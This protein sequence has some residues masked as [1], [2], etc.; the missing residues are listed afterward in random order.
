VSL[1]EQDEERAAARAAALRRQLEE[2]N[3]RYHALDAPTISDAEYDRLLR[4]LIEIEE[5]YPELRDPSSPTQRVGAAPS[6]AF[7]AHVHRVP[8]L[9]L[10][11]SFSLEELREF[12]ARVK[13]MLRLG[14]DAAV[15]YVC[16]LKIDGL[17]VSMTY[18]EGRLVVGATRGDGTQG[19]DVTPNLRTIRSIP[20]SLRDGAPS[21]R[22]EVRGEVYLTH[23]EFQAVN[24]ERE[25]EGLPLFANPRNAAA[26]SLRQLDSSITAR[27]RLQA[28]FYGL[29]ESP[30]TPPSQWELIRTLGEWGFRTNPHRRLCASI[31]EVIPF[32]D[33]W[34]T[35]RAALP[36]EI[37]GVVVKVNERALQEE[38]G[39]VSRSPRWATAYKYP[40]AEATTRIQAIQVQVGRTGALTP[41]AIMDPVVVAGVTVTRAT[42]HNEDEI[43]RKDIRVGDT[44]VIRRAGEVIPEVVA[45]LTEK[46]T[47][48]ETPF[49]MPT[50]CP[51]CGADVERGD[52]EAVARCVGIACPAQVQERLR[53][54][55]SRGA[56]DIDGLGP[57]H[58]EQLV[59]LGF[60]HDPADLYALTKEQ[61]LTLERL[62]ERSAQNLLDA[63]DRSRSRPLARL[64]FGLGIRHVGE[65]VARLLAEHFGSIER[66]RAASEEQLAAV[67]GVGP[68]IAASVARFFRQEETTAALEKLK[69]AGVLPEAAGE[70]EQGERPFAG[71]TFVFTGGLETM[72]R[73]EA[74]EAVRA[75][76]GVA[77]GS[78]SKKTRYVVAGEGGG[79]K[80]ARAQELGVPVI[81]EAEFREM[82]EG[83]G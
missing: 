64:L 69:A 67:P 5:Q 43:R 60:V 82:L 49:V 47:G 7:R 42:L 54:F 4:E 8:M 44:V 29:G 6:S 1:F 30:V 31:D 39:A 20:L 34:Q 19:E 22:V 57:A 74:E 35:E 45:V 56:M 72:T 65:H 36:Y 14:A 62:A 26:G 3:Y 9:S 52:G 80:L 50:K 79:S 24:Q 41:V 70:H 18:A 12:D 17:A 81:S 40:A 77:S 55:A 53:H 13:R 28:F 10:G 38:L 71:M 51:V 25:A 83:A 32:C 75:R 46:R 76:G 2:A 78:V 63:I 16:E 73:P 33:E 37:D 27:R 11:N 48:A 21:G 15:A 68:Q 66:L 58:V 23:D 59:K 61:L